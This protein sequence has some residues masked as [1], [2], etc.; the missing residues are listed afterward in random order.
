MGYAEKSCAS[1][2]DLSSTKRVAPM[3]PEEEFYTQPNKIEMIP[4]S[5]LDKTSFKDVPV[6][7]SSTL[8]KVV[9]QLDIISTTLAVLEQRIQSNEN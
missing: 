4:D 3:R 7:I 1:P 8:S 2:S 5:A 6:E 9:N